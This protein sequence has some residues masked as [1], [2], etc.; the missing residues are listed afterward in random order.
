MNS[1]FFLLTRILLTF[2]LRTRTFNFLTLA[3]L[4]FSL[5]TRGF[6]LVTRRFEF[7]TRMSELVTRVLLFHGCKNQVK[8]IFPLLQKP[9]NL[10]K[11]SVFDSNFFLN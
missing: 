9:V 5:L 2:N 8:I 6:E 4:A 10:D 1:E 3:L 11:L 7:V